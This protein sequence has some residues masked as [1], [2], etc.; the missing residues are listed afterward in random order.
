M[1]LLFQSST[2]CRRHVS[3]QII[4]SICHH[5]HLFPSRLV[6]KH[7][8]TISTAA[9]FHPSLCN[10]AHKH[11]DNNNDINSMVNN[12]NQSRNKSESPFE[13]PSLY[14]TE[15]ERQRMRRNKNIIMHPNGTGKD[16]LPGNYVLKVNERTGLERKVIL[17]HEK[18]Y[19]WAIRVSGVKFSV[20]ELIFVCCFDVL[21]S[22][23]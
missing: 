22:W 18:G 19:F 3:K 6:S 4:K 23:C 9:Q 7:Y 13:Q 8:S 5:H 12:N 14:E 17:E 2:S 20:E 21:L 1:T 11:L 10:H 15:Y 16:I